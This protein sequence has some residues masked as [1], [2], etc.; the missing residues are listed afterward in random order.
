MFQTSDD[1][2]RAFDLL[3]GDVIR[4]SG[5]ALEKVLHFI[6]REPRDQAFRIDPLL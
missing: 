2:K 3:G 1:L 6:A 5:E 4:V